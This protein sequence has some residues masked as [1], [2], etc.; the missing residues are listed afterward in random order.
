MKDG[1]PPAQ[2]RR[3]QGYSTREEWKNIYRRTKNGKLRRLSS[4]ELKVKRSNDLEK[5]YH[6][7]ANGTIEQVF[8]TSAH[9][10][11]GL[12]ASAFEL[13]ASRT[14]PPASTDDGHSQNVRTAGMD[15]PSEFSKEARNA[16]E[17]GIIHARRA[18]LEARRTLPIPSH[19]A[20]YP[21]DEFEQAFLRSKMSVF[22]IFASKAADLFRAGDRSLDRVEQESREFS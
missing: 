15:Y 8:E 19:Y 7:L 21:S 14:Q 18:M 11:H 10:R 17:A 3:K 12:P 6:W 2:V 9:F 20:S 16:V 5:Y 22:L 13:E 4:R 1:K